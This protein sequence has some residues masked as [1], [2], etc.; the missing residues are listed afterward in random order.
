[1]SKSASQYM[2]RNQARGCVLVTVV[3]AVALFVS[4]YRVFPVSIQYLISAVF[5]GFLSCLCAFFARK[6]PHNLLVIAI[7]GLGYSYSLEW[8]YPSA[9]FARHI[10][11]CIAAQWLVAALATC[12]IMLLVHRTKQHTAKLS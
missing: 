9:L 12:L 2:S 7:F 8:F 5:T 10:N 3:V 6:K 4:A 11:I 1:M